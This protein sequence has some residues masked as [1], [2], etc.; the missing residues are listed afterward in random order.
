MQANILV[1]EFGS[2]LITDFGISRLLIESTLWE[3][4]KTS[5]EGSG[6]WMSPELLEGKEPRPTKESDVYAFAMTIIVGIKV[7]LK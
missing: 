1:D 7:F 3:T 2:P 6:R 5:A 4:S